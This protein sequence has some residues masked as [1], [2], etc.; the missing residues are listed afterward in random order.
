MP[1]PNDNKLNIIISQTSGSADGSGKFPFVETLISGSNLFLVTNAAGVL[2]GSTSIPNA[3]FTSLTASNLLVTGNTT[4]G[5]STTDI[6]SITGSTSITGGL[7]VIGGVTGSF[8]GSITSAD[9]SSITNRPNEAGTYYVTFVDGTSG[10]KPLYVDSNILS[11]N[12]NTNL[13][14]VGESASGSLTVGSK[15]TM[16]DIGGTSQ[17]RVGT[18]STDTSSLLVSSNAFQVVKGTTNDRVSTNLPF[19]ASNESLFSSNVTVLG[20]TTL[21]D[22]TSDLI[23]I[24]GSLGISGS[25][26]TNSATFTDL[27]A[28]RVVVTNG[29]QILSTDADLTFDGTTLTATNISNT[30]L[31]SSN[32][33][34]SGFISA[35]RLR[36]ETSIVDGGSLTVI[37]N[38]VLGD[39]VTDT[40]QI[41]GSTSVSGS[42]SVVGNSTL[43]NTF[44]T[45]ISASGNISASNLWIQTSIVDG[46]TL[47]VLGNTTLGDTVSDT[48]RITGSASISGSLTVVGNSVLTTITGALSGSSVST[49]NATINGGSI[50]NTSIGSTTPSTGNF[51][52]LTA[53]NISASN[54]IVNGGSLTVIGNTFL[55]DAITDTTKVT[56]SVSISGSLSVVGGIAGTIETASR[57]VISNVETSA[58][59]HFLTFVPAT[60]GTQPIYTDSSSLSYFPTANR[61]QL[62][63]SGEIVLGDG[64]ASINI[65]TDPSNATVSIGTTNSGSLLVGGNTVFKVNA[66][67]NLT[68]IGTFVTMSNEVS[69]TDTTQATNWDNGALVVAGG[70][71]IGKN[72]Y[73]SGSTF[74]YGDLTIFGSSSVV[75]ISSSTV[76]IGDNRILLN[77]GSPII[78]YAGID[79]YDSGSGGIQT[80]VTSSMLWDSLTDSWILFSANKPGSN[81]LTASSAILI[82]G[83]TSSFGSE[84]TLTTNYLPKAQSS[85]KNLTN[86]LLFDDGETLG[87]TG[88][89]ISASQ[90]TASNAMLLNVYSTNISSST[91]SASNATITNV[92]NTY[93]SSSIISG[94]NLRIQLTGSITYATGVLVTYITGSFNTLTLSTGSY[95]GNA[96]G[97]V[98][99]APTS[100]GMPGQINVDNNFIYV[101]TNNIWKRVPLSQWSN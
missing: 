47:T 70:V 97:L 50:N 56:G 26:S 65:A 88:T 95:P 74:L 25:V 5:N 3:N 68:E 13:L 58:N 27:T 36:V 94:S 49:G 46:G 85:G 42:F 45:N 90:V 22:T 101:Y 51:T 41:T 100:S 7:T 54:S 1:Y 53:S 29:S 55:G 86:S 75:N 62:G 76:V 78:R 69:I 52:N 20:N 99:N 37:G 77:A 39:S 30:N 91:I 21:G 38:T 15:L 64:N 14:S 12:T 2:T 11:Y 16:Q 19:S 60:N 98:P 80:N 61:L 31:T 63:A 67:T 84:A 59:R 28:N 66:F 35:S 9:S 79:V 4:L 87:F 8:S 93:I 71:G 43:Q 82:G 57:V 92:Y 34:V 81:P 18:T 17:L 89:R 33:S 24:T 44:V 32:I 40:T 73:V 10:Y 96:P 6:I 83:P 48:T 23:K 72:L